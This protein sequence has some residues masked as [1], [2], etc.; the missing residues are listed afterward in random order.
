MPLSES[1]LMIEWQPRRVQ[2]YVRNRKDDTRS[3]FQTFTLTNQDEVIECADLGPIEE[4]DEP[5]TTFG[6][7]EVNEP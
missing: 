5:L 3:Q 1:D 2:V 4:A 7:P 6:T